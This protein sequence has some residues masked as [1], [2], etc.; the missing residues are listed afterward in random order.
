MDILDIKLEYEMLKKV[1]AENGW[2]DL[3][4]FLQDMFPNFDLYSVSQDWYWNR[5]YICKAKGVLGDV[6]I[7]WK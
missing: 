2:D 3:L 7:E 1:V 6:I 5:Q 4:I